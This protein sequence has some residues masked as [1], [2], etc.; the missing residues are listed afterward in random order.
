MSGYSKGKIRQ[1][2]LRELIKQLP[3]KQNLEQ[4]RHILFDGK[5]LFGRKYCLAMIF[6]AHANKPIACIVVKAESKKHIGPWLEELKSQ[7][8]NPKSVTTDGNQS[9]IASF[10]DTWPEITVQRCLFHIQLQVLSW[11]RARPRYESARA[12]KELVGSITK[13]KTKAQAKLFEEQFLELCHRYKS[14]IRAFDSTHPVESDSIRAY[15][16]VLNA[17]DK[18]FHYLD[19]PDIAPTT[20]ALEGY[21]KQIQRI[22]GFSHNG[23]TKEHL[24]RAIAWKVFFDS[25]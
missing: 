4:H 20:S 10:M 7:G 8:F 6:D 17:L 25:H 24:F 12:L 9:V 2:I 3:V 13:I 18:C 15:S 14:Q 21:F 23:L 22:K 1:I 5:F 16:L 11:L 19:N